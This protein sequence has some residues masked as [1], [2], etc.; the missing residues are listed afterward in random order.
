M[1]IVRDPKVD[2]LG[3][4]WVFLGLSVVFVLAGGVSMAVGGLNLGWISR[5]EP[6][7]T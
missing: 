6:W 5:V 4:K 7:S 1:D 3:L 2:W